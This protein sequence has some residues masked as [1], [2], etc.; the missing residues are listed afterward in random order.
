M[1]GIYKYTDLMTGDVV[2]V[3][4]DSHI[5]KNMR[6]LQHSAPYKYDEQ[7]IESVDIKKLEQKVK[8]KGLIWRCL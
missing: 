4:K 7:P 6:H 5:D 8:E 2:Y 3:G 1:K